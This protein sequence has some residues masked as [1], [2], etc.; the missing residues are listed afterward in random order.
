MQYLNYALQTSTR[1]LT[2]QGN[3]NQ[4]LYPGQATT[5]VEEEIKH[6]CCSR[7]AQLLRLRHRELAKRRALEDQINCN[8][9][10]E[11]QQDEEEEDDRELELD[12]DQG[13]VGGEQLHPQPVQ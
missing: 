11:E 5:G 2:Y 3:H 4:D 10:E 9:E 8:Q 12:S 6:A 7:G 13:A 1:L